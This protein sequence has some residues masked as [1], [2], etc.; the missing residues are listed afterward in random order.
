MKSTHKETGYI[1]QKEELFTV[2][3]KHKNL[4]VCPYLN[5]FCG[6]KKIKREKITDYTISGFI[7]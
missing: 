7:L 1:T 4:T 2:T 6:P 3:L 5:I